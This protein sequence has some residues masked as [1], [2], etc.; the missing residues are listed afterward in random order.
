MILTCACGS[1]RR[2]WVTK[3][4]GGR[5]CDAGR[6]AMRNSGR[7]DDDPLAGPTGAAGAG[8]CCAAGCGASARRCG[9]GCG[10]SCSGTGTGTV[11]DGFGGGCAAAWG[12]TR[13]AG[14]GRGAYNVC[15]REKK[16][17]IVSFVSFSTYIRPFLHSRVCQILSRT[18]LINWIYFYL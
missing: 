4:L 3:G 16:V 6:W 9:M 17:R 14:S 5:I 2:R 8:A 11:A 12:A 13:A 7:L 1:S 18:Q 15:K 10:T